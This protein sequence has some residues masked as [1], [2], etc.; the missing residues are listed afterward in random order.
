LAYSDCVEI[1]TNPPGYPDIYGNITADPMFV[2]LTLPDLHL[3]PNSPAIDSGASI[4]SLITDYDGNIRPQGIG[5]DIG[6]YE[7]FVIK[8][9]IK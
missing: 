1:S 5:S 8:N 2:S 4:N 9:N 3:L 6:A 7:V